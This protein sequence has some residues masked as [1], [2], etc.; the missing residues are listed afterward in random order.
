MTHGSYLAETD[1][2]PMVRSLE[3]R[4]LV[5][6]G[7]RTVF[8]WA[9]LCGVAAAV[10]LPASSSAGSAG[11][12]RVGSPPAI[13]RAAKA[14]GA[15]PAGVRMHLT[16]VLKPRDPA[17]LASFARAVSTPGSSVYRDYLTPAQFAG[18]FG[19]TPDQ[20][21]AVRASLIAHGLNPGALSPNGL[22]IPVIASA[23]QTEHAFSLT[24]RRMVLPDGRRATLASAAPALDAK[25]APEVQA[26]LGLS[27]TNALHPQYARRAIL[28][29]KRPASLRGSARHVATGGPQPCSQASS[30]ASAQGAYTADQIASAYGFS[31]MYQA[32]DQGQ[33]ETIAVY[34]LEPNDPNDIAAYQS[35]YGTHAAV[36][37]VPV[38]GGAG[39]GQG[40]G[41][42]ALDIENAIGLA[43]RANILVYQG[44]N[45]NQ[46]VPGSGPF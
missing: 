34:E 29:G 14:V 1:T 35:C 20:V 16:V 5:R 41:E 21:K 15:L 44:P 10:A 8:R 32:G 27:S 19:A 17:A 18:R 43:P 33:G 31:S 38:D 39:T 23:S 12:V 2:D 3:S 4:A 42:A 36:S 26:V 30:A 7:S 25:I 46:S 24:M 11:P 9:C 13:A 22:S 37:Y 28:G 6:W 40:S 45:A